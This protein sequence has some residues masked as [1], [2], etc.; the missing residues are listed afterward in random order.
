[1]F[2][3]FGYSGQHIYNFLDTRH[4]QSLEAA[5]ERLRREGEAAGSAAEEVSYTGWRRVVEWVA[6]PK[7]KYS[8]IRKLSDREYEEMLQEKLI[9]VE[10]DLAMVDEEIEKTKR[11][12]LDT[13]QK[14][15]RAG[16]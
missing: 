2:A 9:A 3:L 7:R 11:Q 8:P 13:R 12:E 10:A 6:D 5:H 15:E 1:M 16:G 4:S 14:G